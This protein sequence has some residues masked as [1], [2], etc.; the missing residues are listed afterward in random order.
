MADQPPSSDLSS[1]V[2]RRDYKENVRSTSA[3][4]FLRRVVSFPPDKIYWIQL[5]FSTK[6][7]NRFA[8]ISHFSQNFFVRDHFASFL[9][10]VPSWKILLQSIS[11]KN[12]TENF[13]DFS[14]NVS[15]AGPIAI[16]SELMSS[17]PGLN[18]NWRGYINGII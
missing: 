18:E 16:Y 6:R 14:R 2:R 3:H 1:I 15:F 4:D 12:A 13:R 11:Q 17:A 8:K 5:W 10:F 9:H 7:K